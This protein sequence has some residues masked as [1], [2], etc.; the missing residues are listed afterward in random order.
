M[1]RFKRIGNWNHECLMTDWMIKK[2]DKGE[3]GSTARSL[4]GCFG[5]D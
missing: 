4:T 2:I 1:I 3:S 5:R